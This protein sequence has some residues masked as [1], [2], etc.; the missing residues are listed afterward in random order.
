MSRSE[1]KGERRETM[2]NIYTTIR[3]LHKDTARKGK[4]YLCIY[5]SQQRAG[6]L[7]L[8][9]VIGRRPRAI[10]DRNAKIIRG[11]RKRENYALQRERITRSQCIICVYTYIYTELGE[12]L[13]SAFGCLP[14]SAQHV[15]WG[16]KRRANNAAPRPSTF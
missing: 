1:K 2:N 4:E 13:S 12:T 6:L 9:C 3:V 16:E 14:L 15:T 7:L 10:G 11:R 5:Y 8:L